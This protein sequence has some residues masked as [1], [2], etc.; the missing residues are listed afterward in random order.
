[1]TVTYD[2]YEAKVL[3][4]VALMV[5]GSSTFQTL[6]GAISAA[7]ARAYVV[8]TEKGSAMAKP[9]ALVHSEEYRQEKLAHGVYG[10][11]G[12]ALVIVHTTN[13]SGDTDPEI[14]RRLRNTA[15]A[16][17]TEMLAL[18]GQPTYLSNCTIDVEG[19]ARRD[20][21]GADRGTAQII[22]NVK[23]TCP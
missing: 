21:T 15:G 3:E 5:A 18:M 20:E 16:I 22:L 1:V 14:H 8:E 23:W 12:E 17:K 19:P 10:H 13:T 4:C 6:V 9:Y 2:S 11:S 7:A